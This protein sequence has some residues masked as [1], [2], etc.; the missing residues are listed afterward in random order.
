MDKPKIIVI[1]GPTATGK[2]A[3]GALLA[4]TV[5]GEV[6]SADSMQVYKLMDIGTAKP[7]AEETLGV[8]HHMI[9]I[10]DPWENYSAA[11]YVSEAARNVNDIIHRGNLPVIVGGTGLYIESLLSG[12]VFSARGDA[13]LR[14]EIEC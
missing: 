3:F 2:T 13:T 4:K 12:R 7:T 11:R 6:V 1:T 9:D 14:Q 5:G 8:A 10:V